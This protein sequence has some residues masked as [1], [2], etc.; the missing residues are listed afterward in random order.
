MFQ[1]ELSPEQH[2][3]LL[4]N[5]KARFEKNINRHQGLEWAKVQASTSFTIVQR[6]VL[7]AAEVFAMTTK[8]SSRENRTNQKITLWTWLRLWVLNF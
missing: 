3:D 2:K 6:K 7:K 4:N 1:K 5:L 8:R